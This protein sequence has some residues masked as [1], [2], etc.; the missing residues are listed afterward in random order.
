MG[1]LTVS[2][3]TDIGMWGVQAC[4]VELELH[5]PHMHSLQILHMHS[6]HTLHTLHTN[7]MN[8]IPN[9]SDQTSL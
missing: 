8:E 3:V 1:C 2:E 9:I 6:L 5:T 4:I 7:E